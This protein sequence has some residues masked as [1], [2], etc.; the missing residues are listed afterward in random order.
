MPN[1]A[2]KV[3]HAFVVFT[4]EYNVI[5]IEPINYQHFIQKDIWLYF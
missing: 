4:L 1:M 2:K 3:N 5:I